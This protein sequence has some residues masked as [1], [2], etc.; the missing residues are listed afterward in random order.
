MSTTFT[1]T[2]EPLE[3]DAEQT[4]DV[5]FKVLIYVVGVLG[6]LLVIFVILFL[7]EYKKITHWYVLQMA[8]ADLIFLQVLPFR[9][10]E[11]FNK[12]WIH[13]VWLCKA[14]QTVVFF[15]YYASI[16]FLMIMA[17]DRYLAVCHPLA[18]KIQSIRTSRNS[19]IVALVTWIISLALSIP[20]ML[21][22]GT[23]GISPTCIC[24]LVFP[25]DPYVWC[26]NNGFDKTESALQDCID[27]TFP[28][29]YGETCQ[30]NER[31]S[32]SSSGI[33]PTSGLDGMS[34]FSGLGGLIPDFLP[35]SGAEI[36]PSAPSTSNTG[37]QISVGCY[38]DPERP[39]WSVFIFFNFIV[40]FV[41]PL[42]VIIV[43]YGLIV[44]RLMA[45]SVGVHD[46]KSRNSTDEGAS[47]G[48]KPTRRRSSSA[49]ASRS[50]KEKVRVTMLCG[51]L[52]FLF[53]VCW[54][55][56]HSVHIAKIFGIVT[57]DDMLC[58]RAAAA[59]VMLAYL[60]SASNPYMYNFLG[61]FKKRMKQIKN[62]K[63]MQ[64][65][66]SATGFTRTSG[67]KSS[68]STDALKSRK[69]IVSQDAKDAGIP[70]ERIPLQTLAEK[71]EPI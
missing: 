69:S 25:K 18:N 53:T 27:V 71:T 63:R 70:G 67:G 50:F 41:I 13:A 14:Q 61:S 39:G 7:S 32:G 44:H 19:Y 43:C 38:Y 60:S 56:F 1:A 54:L 58:S 68:V 29:I 51:M 26:H 64:S 62:H 40:M 37:R 59:T 49:A 52:A 21:Y 24:S 8:F 42:L 30:V 20:V 48:F 47:K 4:A 36:P 2:D 9:L 23:V 31:E 17:I 66:L 3:L 55:P 11:I 57:D 6:N 12:R 15:T 35:E 45:A 22:S 33:L 5:V 46:K 28:S 65:F 16:L 34:G 10:S